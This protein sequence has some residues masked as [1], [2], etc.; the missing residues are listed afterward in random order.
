MTSEP[1][2]REEQRRRTR[3]AL[4]RAALDIVE[5]DGMD[6]L[7]AT[8]VA[9]EAGVSRR[10]FFN[11]FPRVEDV[12]TARIEAVTAETLAA[13]IARPPEESL[14]VAV[15]TVLDQMVDTPAIT[16]ALVLERVARRSPATRR[17][18]REFR[19]SQS[20]A[21]E[22]GIRARLGD[23]ADPVFVASLAACAAAL[24][25]RITRMSVELEDESAGVD[26][27]HTRLRQAFDLLF[28]GFDEARCLPEGS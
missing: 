28:S 2:L 10:T 24:T 27:L 22:Q 23:D 16:Q 6:E 11:Y 13:V 1:G 20:T 19:D 15:L 4:V 18:L 9:E 14:R 5:R 8:R 26:L 3:E 21:F 7:T 25:E 12:L 17:F